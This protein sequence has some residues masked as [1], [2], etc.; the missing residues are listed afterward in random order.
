MTADLISL[1]AAR[2]AVLDAVPGPLAAEEVHTA[3]ALGRV[4][5][6]D[7]E[8]EHDLPPFDNSAMDGYAVAAGP[9]R[10]LEVVGESRAGRPAERALAEG[11]AIRIST[12]AVVPEGADAVV[13][14]EL[15]SLSDG[16][17]TI[18]EAAPGANVRRAGEDVHAGDTVLTA[19]AELGPAELGVLSSLGHDRVSCS[20][21]PRVA[22]VVTGDEL[23]EPGRPLRPGEIRDSNAAALAAQAT[24]AGADVVSSER[25]GDDFDATV[26]ALDRATADADMVCIAGGVSVGEHDHVKGALAELGAGERF[27]G[28]AIKPGKPTWFGTCRGVPVL[29]VPGNP[30][31]AMVIF[32]LLGRPALRWLGGADTA[33]TRTTAVLDAEVSRSPAR[34]QALRCRLTAARDG[35]HVEPTKAQGSHVLT[36]MLGAGALA[37]IPAGDGAVERGERVE[38]ELLPR[39]TLSG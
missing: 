31:S 35:W 14:V 25:V 33:D 12:G 18:P 15:A 29:G 37:L 27:W 22:L 11:Q 20:R 4:L 24:R 16:R 30:V 8:A 2:R 21:R 34:A 36:S 13:P 5:A 3:E 32:H 19:G 9:P 1:A 23:V 7:V 28:V 39:G 26:A 6:G 38:I 17:V 10:E